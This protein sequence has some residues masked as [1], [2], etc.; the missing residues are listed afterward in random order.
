MID[1]GDLTRALAAIH[2]FNGRFQFEPWL[3]RIAKNL[4]IDESRREQ[5]RASPVDPQE[6]PNITHASEVDLVWDRME[7]RFAEGLVRQTLARLPFRHRVVLVLREIEGLSYSQIAQ[8]IGTNRSR[9]GGNAKASPGRIPA[10][11]G[12]GPIGE[13]ESAQCRRTL[14]LIAEDHTSIETARYLGRCEACRVKAAKIRKAD[15][16]WAL[17]PPS[18]GAASWLSD[19]TGRFESSTPQRPTDLPPSPEL[20]AT[21]PSV[22]LPR[23]RVFRSR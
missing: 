11:S 20:P 21:I 10:A 15:K 9:S 12:R 22:A 6:I 3:L 1:P 13:S 19:L 4:V 18:G 14:R 5:H 7:E 17:L 16:A 23:R 8:I 2:R